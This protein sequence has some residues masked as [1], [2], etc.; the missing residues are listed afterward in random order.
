MKLNIK[1]LLDFF[2]D[3]KDSQKGDANALMAML[4]EDLNVSVY[5]DFRKKEVKI[6]EETISQGF[7]KGKRLDRWILDKENKK[8]F[9]CEIKNWAATAIGGKQLKSN[10]S[11]EETKKVVKDYWSRELKNNF[12]KRVK[13]PN[14]ITKVLLK[15]KSPDGYRNISNIQPL[16]IYWMP[17]SL[18][19]KELNPISTLPVK[20]LNL[21]MSH[22]F[23]KL[24]IFSVSLYLRQLYKKGKGRKFIYLDMPH[25]EHRM[26]LLTKFQ[27]KK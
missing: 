19:K 26:K 10:A 21:P 25:L 16:L 20:P 2:D 22:N 27:N 4:G 13:H 5:R 3:K 8:L 23:S 18:D 15:M 12:S 7:K 6:L 17:I 11:D 1:E 24:H 9:Q 14:S